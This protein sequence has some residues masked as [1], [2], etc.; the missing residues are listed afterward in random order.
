MSERSVATNITLM[1]VLFGLMTGASL[2]QAADVTPLMSK[3]LPEIPGREV[4]MITVEKAPGGADPILPTPFRIGETSAAA[5][6]AVGLAVSEVWKLRTGRDQDRSVPTP[7]LVEDDDGIDDVVQP[8]AA[9][10]AAG[11]QALEELHVGGDDDGCGPIFHRK[12]HLVT[13]VA[14]A[15]TPHH[16]L[17][18]FALE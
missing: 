15:F 4:L 11:E 9:R 12:P 5:L 17:A 8:A 14:L 10:G 1:L 18:P 7:T 2:A 3:D 6:A 16:Q 13:Q